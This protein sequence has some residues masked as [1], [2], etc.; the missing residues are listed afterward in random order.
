MN[1]K[2]RLYSIAVLGGGSWGIAFSVHLYSLGHKVSI[3]E[4]NRE[5]A[6][7]LALRREHKTKLPGVMIPN[8][9]EISNNLSEVIKDAEIIVIAIPSHTVR[10]VSRKL[11]ELLSD[12]GPLIVNLSKGLEVES[13][14]RMS[15]VIIEELDTGYKN[16]V[17]TLSGP[18]HAE[19]VSRR[20]PTTVAIAGQDLQNLSYVQ[21]AFSS[22]YFR[23]YTNADLIGVELAGSLKNVI[24]IAAGICDGLG[25]GD[26]TKGALLTR[27]L[28]EMTRLGVAMGAARE[29]FS[30][31]AGIGDLVATCLSGHSRNRLFGEKIGKGENFDDALSEMI[32][33]AEG[34]KTTKVAVRLAD[35][36]EVEMPIAKEVF[37]VL[38]GGKEPRVA[39]IDLMTREPKSEAYLYGK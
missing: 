17:M 4:F 37:N 15:E 30:G 31:L 19:E 38:F 14:K 1:D 20:M 23:V 39:V 16:K 10:S 26:N 12:N 36:Y 33:V 35:K 32:M 6:I 8:E 7:E 3:W 22:K 21:N 11:S 24:A 5:D 9:I 34:I 18:S 25:L 13:L 28:A 29:T 27:G 2:E